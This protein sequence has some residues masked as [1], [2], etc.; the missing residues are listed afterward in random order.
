MRT[1]RT[2]AE[3]RSV[4]RA[5][6]EEYGADASVGF[7]PTM[8]ALHEGHLSLVSA[9]RAEHSIVVLSIFVNPTQFD[10]G[11]DFA[12]YPRDEQRDAA[13][14]ERAG[15]DLLFAPEAT[16][17]YPDGYSTTIAVGGRLTEVLEGEQRGSSHFDGV[18]TVVGKLLI[19]VQPDAAYFGEKDY[20]Q[21]LVVRRLVSDLGLPVRIVGC[22]TLREDD[23]L[24]RSSRNAR[25]GVDD[26]RRAGAIPAALAAV[27]DAVR[28]GE[29]DAEALRAS[30]RVR[31]EAAGLA[32]EY[33]AFVDP[34]SLEA[35]DTVSEPTLFA[36]AARSGDTRLIDNHMLD[37]WNPER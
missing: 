25:L 3:L 8:G 17:M 21:L 26:R 33:L 27:A 36:V 14:A 18:A 2:V 32:I 13:L 16:E 11:E 4:L 20:Q 34:V 6:R 28:G 9:A 5:T 12:R 15:V 22:P 10:E 19:A 37:P 30:A 29:R 7:V 35:V 1:I 23:G 31:L 24:A